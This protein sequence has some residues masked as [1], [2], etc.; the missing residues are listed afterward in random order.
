[1]PFLAP[2]NCNGIFNTHSGQVASVIVPTA[3]SKVYGAFRNTGNAIYWGNAS[4]GGGTIVSTST[5][6][7]A[8]G[9]TANRSNT[10]ISIDQTI[11][12][13]FNATGAN[14]FR[15][16]LDTLLQDQTQ[17]LAGTSGY[18]AVDPAT[19]RLFVGMAN[20]TVQVRNKSD[21]TVLQG[22]INCPGA[23]G[24]V[25]VFFEP[26]Q[27]LIVARSGSLLTIFDTNYNVI[28]SVAADGNIASI[29]FCSITNTFFALGNQVSNSKEISIA[30]VLLNSFPLSIGSSL[31]AAF[32]PS[33]GYIYVNLFN[34]GVNAAQLALVNPTTRVIDL[35]TPTSG[36]AGVTLAYPVYAPNKRTIYAINTDGS[37]AY[38]FN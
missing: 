23:A 3:T 16:N 12:R 4:A 7:A 21:V 9:F 1:M 37:F 32:S 5:N 29:V 18:T 8:A 6:T 36:G 27:N 31:G 19:D 2:C 25:L 14:L 24:S 26:T 34:G 20:G 13:G 17:A 15:L 22:T 30:G 38:E 35:I 33:S 28:G 10:Q 11:D